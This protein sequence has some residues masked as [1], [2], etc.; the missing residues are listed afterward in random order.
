MNDIISVL[1]NYPVTHSLMMMIIMIIIII[2]DQ[3]VGK[4]SAFTLSMGMCWEY[5]AFLYAQDRPCMM[6]NHIPQEVALLMN[7]TR[8]ISRSK[9]KKN[10][11]VQGVNY[12]TDG[13][14]KHL[15]WNVRTQEWLSSRS[16]NPRFQAALLR[17]AG[18]YSSGQK[19]SLAAGVT[20]IVIRKQ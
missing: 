13:L 19:T 14:Q 11:L 15:Q 10:P 3:G 4:R 2:K 8:R 9:Q 6:N 18:L 17:Q 5:I 12:R 1:L 7:R 16:G 20:A